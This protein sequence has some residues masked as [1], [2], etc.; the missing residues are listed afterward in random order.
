MPTTA[1]SDLS[2]E[3]R[4]LALVESELALPARSVH[5]DT[6]IAS[7]G[8]SLDWLE[9]LMAVEDAFGVELEPA[10]TRGVRSVGD[11]LRLLQPQEASARLAA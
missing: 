9:L 3:V 8:D 6:P 11:L 4:L 5:V 2:C 10:A 1:P 7:I